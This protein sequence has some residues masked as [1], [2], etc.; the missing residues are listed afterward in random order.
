MGRYAYRNQPQIAH[1]NLARLVQSLLPLL[2]KDQDKAIAAGQA[3]IDAFPNLVQTAYRDGM[4]KKLGLAGDDPGDTVLVQDLLNLMQEYKTDFTLTFRYLT[5]LV[6]PETASGGGVSPIFELPVTFAP[7]LER[8]R[9]RL[10]NDSREADSRQSGMYA[11]N[12][13]FIPRNHLVGE[14]IAAAQTQQNFDPFHKLVDILARPF[15]FEASDVRYARPPR[16]E[17]VVERTF[18]GT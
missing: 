16:P 4:C 2:D 8:W 10:A 5:D 11:V 7:W 15:Q 18:C 6:A 14:A 9:E 17:Q 13:V 3:V 12:P 1:W